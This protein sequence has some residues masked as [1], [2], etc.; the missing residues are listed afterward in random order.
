MHNP[1]RRIRRSEQPLLA[2]GYLLSSACDR[3]AVPLLAV[4]TP[5]GLFVAGAGTTDAIAPELLGGL[6]A[7]ASATHGQLGDRTFFVQ[8]LEAH[9]ISFRLTS[10]DQ[11]VSSEPISAGFE[12]ILSN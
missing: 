7:A 11:P 2:L 9:G 12:R 4:T 10:L 5:D 3:D 8:T 6:G 1:E